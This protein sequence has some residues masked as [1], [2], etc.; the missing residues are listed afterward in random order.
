M[1]G[2]KNIWQIRND[3]PTLES[4]EVHVW[5]VSIDR[6]VS[7]LEKFLETLSPDER[8][9][10][11][12]FRFEKDRRR[13]IIA[14]GTLRKLLGVY[15]KVSPAEISFSYNPFG[16]PVVAESSICFNI[17][18]SEGVALFGFSDGQEIGIDLEFIKREFATVKVA[19]QFCSRRELLAL[20]A[21]STDVR[22]PVFFDVWTQKEAYLKA[23]GTGFSNPADQFT[24]PMI[25]DG[26]KTRMKQNAGY[27]FRGWTFF[28]LEAEA[29]YSAAL[30]VNGTVRNVRYL[31]F[32]DS[33]IM[34]NKGLNKVLGFE[35]AKRG[36]RQCA[37]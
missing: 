30:A 9:R 24:L 3:P 17:S 35:I 1:S 5:R 28:K 20:D 26:H 15:L 19:E 29:D 37:E 2:K 32:S 36:K 12:R 34:E 14:R 4:G 31:R 11:D 16:K 6:N 8:Q 21:L 27:K 13:F 23:V 22:I 10:A 33:N 18:Y 25:S 7:Q